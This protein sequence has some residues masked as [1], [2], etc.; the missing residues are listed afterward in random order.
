MTFD[1]YALMKRNMLHVA[2]CMF[3]ASNE[4]EE[5]GRALDWIYFDDEIIFVLFA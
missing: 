5:R 2:C 1:F 3:F 4:E